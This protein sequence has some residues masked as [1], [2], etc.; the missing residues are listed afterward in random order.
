MQVGISIL[1]TLPSIC[2]AGPAD[3]G[4]AGQ[5]ERAHPIATVTV[6][7]ADFSSDLTIADWRAGTDQQAEAT[8]RL[9]RW[10]RALTAGIG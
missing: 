3:R 2:P 10:T 8:S 4:I 7:A 1:A 5:P 9:A 6:A